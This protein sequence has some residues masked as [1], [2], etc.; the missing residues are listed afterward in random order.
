MDRRDAYDPYDPRAGNSNAPLQP[1]HTPTPN[2]ALPPLPTVDPAPATAPAPAFAPYHPSS[3]PSSAAAEY[4]AHNAH[5]HASRLAPS[6]H[7]RASLAGLS[8][9]ESLSTLDDH[10][11]KGGGRGE[12][13]GQGHIP[14]LQATR[15]GKSTHAYA[16]AQGQAPLSPTSAHASP[17]TTLPPLHATVG[18]YDPSAPSFGLPRAYGDAYEYG[19]GEYVHGHG[20]EYGQGHGHGH[21][22]PQTALP[23]GHDSQWGTR[24][25]PGSDW[26]SADIGAQRDAE[27]GS[28]GERDRLGRY[29]RDRR[30][31][32]WRDDLPASLSSRR[33]YTPSSTIP[34]H[35]QE[36]MAPPGLSAS[37]TRSQASHASQGPTRRASDARTAGRV[38]PTK[39]APA[40]RG[41]ADESDSDSGDEA[42]KADRSKLEIKREKNRVKQ[43]N[44]RRV[45]HSY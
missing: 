22:Y 37:A 19:R 28:N 27:R 4:F 33:P 44:L 30:E 9:N 15:Y 6:A 1:S 24:R 32:S 39:V 42:D 3:A 41:R 12:V 2:S 5:L 21:G 23:L 38:S 18:R 25:E 31:L 29:D 34:S 10:L 8:G 17:Y 43:R 40:K 20:R 14:P 26:R 35:R 36:H 11:R 7:R 45:S 16:H 13:P